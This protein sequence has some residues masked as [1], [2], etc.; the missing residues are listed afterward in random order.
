MHFI[1]CVGMRGGIG[2]QQSGDGVALRMHFI[3]C[4]GTRGRIGV[5]QSGDGVAL[6]LMHFIPCVGT[7]GRVGVQQSG[8]GVARRILF[9]GVGTTGRI[10]VLWCYTFHAT[11][12]FLCTESSFS[13]VSH[14]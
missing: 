4:V 8:D 5:Q 14:E 9:L 13:F 6:R 3:P 12:A 2:V 7:R 10:V 11:F 1:P